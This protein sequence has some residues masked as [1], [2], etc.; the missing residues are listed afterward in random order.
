M[1]KIVHVRYTLKK[2][3]PLEKALKRFRRLCERA[4]IRADVRRKRFFEKPS[5]SKRREQRRNE[6]KRRRA[7][8]K[9]AEKKERRLKKMKAARKRGARP[10]E[11]EATAA[12]REP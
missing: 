3:E 4:S 9:A 2:D 12:E 7:E 8:L 11:P 5:E 6:R 10:A 1:G